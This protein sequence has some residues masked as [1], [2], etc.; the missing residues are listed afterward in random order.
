MNFIKQNI[1]HLLIPLISIVLGLLVGAIIMWTGGYDPI[2]GYAQLWNGMF[3]EAYQTGELVRRATPLILAGLAVAFAFKSGLFNIGVEG[4]YLMG[5][6]AAVWVG[7]TFEFPM[8]LHLPLAILAAM[9]AGSLWAFIP[10]FL[11][12]TR[13]VH[14][15]VVTIMMNLAALPIVNHVLRTVLT[16]GGARTENVHASASLSSEFLRELTNK[17]SMHMGFLIAFVAVI[18]V[19]FIIEK[20]TIGYEFRA[21]GFNRHASEYAGMN[22]KRNIVYSMMISGGLAGIA[23]AMEGLGGFG[24]LAIQSGFTGV[25]FDGIAVALLGA[26][27]PIGILLA[28]FLFAGLRTGAAYYPFSLEAPSEI[29]SVVIATILFF[30][31]IQYVIRYLLDKIKQ[32]GAA[33]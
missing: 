19:W 18:V 20:T 33:K 16:D 15:V 21:V 25:G 23:G 5:Y 10:G 29:I 26:G 30:I 28:G 1:N 31:A 24:Y 7:V 6:L 11:K 8:I 12:A 13:G 4:Q 3:G 9:I 32:K 2:A 17:S 27:N 14:E 22:V